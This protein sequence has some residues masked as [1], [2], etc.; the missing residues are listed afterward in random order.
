M[1]HNTYNFQPV[2]HVIEL[3]SLFFSIYP[4]HSILRGHSSEASYSITLN[5]KQ[6]RSISS[7]PV[8][9]QF[10]TPSTCQLC[11][12]PYTD[13]R[14]LNC[15]HS[16]CLECILKEVER[17]QAKRDGRPHQ[18]FPCPACNK[19]VSIPVGGVKNLP[20]DLHLDFEVKVAQYR[21]RIAGSSKT[22]C[23]VC[24]DD[25]SGSA[26][27]FCCTCLKFLCQLCFTYHQ[28]SR[29][30]HL[31]S[32]LALD[33]E[34]SKERL[35]TV[36]PPEPS[37]SLHGKKLKFYCKG[38][39]D[40][41]CR[42]C[43]V[44]AHKG[45]THLE[46]P[47]TACSHRDEINKLLVSAKEVMLRLTT[48]VDDNIRML[49]GVEASEKNVSHNI[50]ETFTQL[51]QAL[52][53]KMNELLRELH[54]I[55]ISKTTA[56][57]LQKESFEALKVDIDHYSNYSS[58]VVQ[59]Y[60]DHELMALKELPSMQLQTVL[61]E[62]GK[63]T[64]LPCRS[65]EIGLVLQKDNLVRELSIFGHVLDFLPSP[66]KST[67]VPKSLPVLNTP[68]QLKVVAYGSGGQ[69][70]RHGGLQVMAEMK[71]KVPA[72][73]SGKVE[74]LKDGTYIITLTPITIGPQQLVISMYGQHVANSPYHLDVMS[75]KPG[76]NTIG[77][78]QRVLNQSIPSPLCMAIHND[79]ADIFIGSE[80]DCIYIF[81]QA[82]VQ[83]AIIG[84]AGNA[85]G[86]FNKPCGLAIKGD[87]LY[88]ADCN[89]HRIQK[90]N[91]S[92]EFL[93][94]FGT[95]GSG[96]G[97]FNFPCAVVIDSNDRLVVADCGNTRI[98]V[99]DI[100]GAF[101]LSIGGLNNMMGFQ[102]GMGF[103]T[104]LGLALDPHGNIHVLN[105]TTIHV[106][107]PDGSFTTQYAIPN[108]KGITINIDGE[109]NALVG[110]EVG[111]VIHILN[112]RGQLC[113][114]L[115]TPMGKPMGIDFDPW[116]GSVYVVISSQDARL[117]TMRGMN[118][119]GQNHPA[120]GSGTLLKYMYRV[121]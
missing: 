100:E 42:D 66:A 113:H 89:N 17:L 88:V 71:P 6:T 62:A 80:T 64:L 82:G 31:H 79:S 91:V 38:C 32:V 77:R 30:L 23:D 20:Q 16:F 87:V 112:P 65:S 34:L 54:S 78:L 21:G 94:M 68:Y 116:D 105:S 4:Q 61:T 5:L 72:A 98:Q 50:R 84:S 15:L 120:A 52:D 45:H 111:N 85:G 103:Q 114:S 36:R 2:L 44:V 8:M 26:V 86:Q 12:Q 119:V 115:I 27:G 83:K 92:G 56:L 67:C 43:T 95:L 40:L 73:V 53:D 58:H 3:Q 24:I 14:V 76:Y 46:L 57:R 25:S 118:C 1:S 106:F 55:A 97:N 107:K 96:Q 75:C 51:H 37:C 13:P 49:E 33:K 7:V 90:L 101:L 48:A 109:G 39:N 63:V 74:D 11:A 110:N 22:A 35:A 41:I 117:E 108:G 99:M 9:E 59:S 28:R 10:Q 81:N 93:H 102:Y 29:E 69:R 18:D 19:F 104:V 121:K 70:C 47:A 60:H